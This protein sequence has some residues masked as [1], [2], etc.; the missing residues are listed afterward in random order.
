MKSFFPSR[1]C[2]SLCGRSYYRGKG[3]HS[4]LLFV[5]PCQT[6]HYFWKTSSPD[7]ANHFLVSFPN[8]HLPF[9]VKVLML[10]ALVTALLVTAQ[11]TAQP[12]PYC[13]PVR[14]KFSN[15]A[16]YWLHTTPVLRSHWSFDYAELVRRQ[17]VDY[18]N[19]W[20]NISYLFALYVST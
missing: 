14:E 20:K 7:V 17:Y 1:P 2:L 11:S 19:G 13:H 16:D 4:F 5:S 12:Q 15:N 3:K 6:P 8:P 10:L 18:W 9:V